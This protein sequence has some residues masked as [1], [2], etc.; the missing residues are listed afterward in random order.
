VTSRVRSRGISPVVTT[1]ILVAVGV[2]LAVA[3][4]VWVMG[5]AGGAA[6]YAKVRVIDARLT[7]SDGSVS[8][9]SVTLANDGTADAV[10]VMIK[11]YDGVADI[12]DTTI[13]AGTTSQSIDVQNWGPPPSEC[14]PGREYSGEVVLADGTR[15]PFV[16][17]AKAEGGG[18]GGGGGE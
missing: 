16:V 8:T 14:T 9:F 13:A 6:K 10:V 1:I 17:V 5:L 12:D 3:V 11:L 15:I 7:C 18:G 2:A 4:A